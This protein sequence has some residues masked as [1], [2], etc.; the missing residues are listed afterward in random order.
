MRGRATRWLVGALGAAGVACGP[1]FSVF[2][3]GDSRPAVEMPPV[4]LTGVVFEGFHGDLRDLSMKASSATVD[5]KTHVAHMR[6]VTI[7]FADDPNSK[8]DISAPQ[9][10]FHL[11]ADDFELTGGVNGT[12][13]ADEHFKSDAVSYVAKTRVLVSE[14]PVELHRSSVV[15]TANRMEFEVPTHKLHLWGNVHAKVKPQ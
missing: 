10:D 3:N 1:S 8:V 4:E 5:M 12:T 14:V 2:E 11:D 9:G 7:G 6:D 15:M 13:A